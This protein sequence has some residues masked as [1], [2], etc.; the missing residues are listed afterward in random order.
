MTRKEFIEIIVDVEKQFSTQQLLVGGVDI[1]PMVRTLLFF[2]YH[3]NIHKNI[4]STAVAS[5]KSNKWEKVQRLIKLPIELFKFFILK[6]LNVNIET[7]F[8]G[9]ISEHV[10]I[11]NKSVNRFHIAFIERL[12]KD[13]IAYSY[14][15]TDNM[16]L[17]IG[18]IIIDIRS[19]V[20]V[21]RKWRKLTKSNMLSPEANKQLEVMMAEV[22][23]RAQLD[24][25]SI[26]LHV[27]QCIESFMVY[28]GVFNRLLNRLRPKKIMCVSYYG[29]E[30]YALMAACNS[31]GIPTVDIQHGGIGDLHIAYGNFSIIPQEGYK[32]LPKYFWVWN[33]QSANYIKEWSIH[34]SFHEVL[35]GGNPWLSF[36]QKRLTKKSS[37]EKIILFTMQFL[38]LEPHI[39]KMIRDTAQD[40]TWYL[41]PHPTWSHRVEELAEQLSELGSEDRVQILPPESSLPEWLFKCNI[42][43]S[44]YSGSII[45]AS[46]TGTYSIIID[47]LGAYTFNEIIESG[48]AFSYLGEE[49]GTFIDLIRNIESLPGLSSAVL[50]IRDV[51][52]LYS[53][54]N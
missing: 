25:A 39:K 32:L 52:K 29:P 43:I 33:E 26:E 46:L 37:K 11:N 1:W 53:S 30:I 19:L 40:Y 51:H 16:L 23:T 49:E 50:D 35:T 14:M 27:R 24:K 13:G 12:K 3:K 41:K 31:R 5:I 38:E 15:N 22:C 48:R 36:C 54:A 21:S 17:P 42:H 2:A 28:K 10:V 4:S 44:K 9:H 20:F 8:T 34:Q 7:L 45:E 18:N 6:F 47:P